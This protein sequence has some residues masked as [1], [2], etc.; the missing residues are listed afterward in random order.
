VDERISV[1]PGGLLEVDVEMGEGLRPDPGSLEVVSHDADEVWVFADASG[2]GA[3]G[4]QFRLEKTPSSVRLYGRVKGAFAWLFGG[5]QIRVRVWVP[6]EFSVDARASSGPITIEEIHGAVRARTRDGSIEL[7]GAEGSVKLRSEGG[8]VRVSEVLGNVDIKSSG[9][10]VEVSWVRGR[11]EARTESGDVSV[12]HVEGGVLARTD[13]GEIQLAE[14]GGE[15]DAKTER[16][17]VF[18]SLLGEPRGLLETRSGSVEVLVPEGAGS[19]LE[20][21]SAEGG[22]VLSP[23]LALEGVREED[24]AVG[25]LNGGGA[26]LRLYTARGT[27]RVSAR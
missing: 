17:G 9:G 23:G 10:P 5:P 27:I 22:V 16:G 7:S 4:V 1:E 8:G 12:K 19:E 14:V 26:P 20:A 13:R 15:V 24:R 2:W 25:R 6:R 11:V 21:R 18:A 3:S